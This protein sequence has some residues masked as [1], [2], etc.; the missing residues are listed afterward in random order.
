MTIL[1]LFGLKMPES[2]VH[3][4][5]FLS[6]FL[7]LVSFC[8]LLL[9][10]SSFFLFLVTFCFLFLFVSLFRWLRSCLWHV[11]VLNQ[12]L[13]SIG[14][15]VSQLVRPLSS[16]SRKRLQ[17]FLRYSARSQ[18]TKSQRK[19]TERFFEKNSQKNFRGHF[20]QKKPA[21]LEKHP[22]R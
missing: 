6:L 10:F 9:F 22:H 16:S 4:V 12:R 1:R 15:L 14:D 17:G 13:S 5:Y 2:Q 19:R 11:A 8:L 20:P 7:F 21:Q 18:G 3:I